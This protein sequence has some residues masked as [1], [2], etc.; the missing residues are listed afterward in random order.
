MTQYPLLSNIIVIIFSFAIIVKASDLLVFGIS[1]YARKFGISDFLIGFLVLS[2]GAS[3]PEFVSSIM[4]GFAGDGGVVFGTIL[5]SCVTAMTLS[6]GITA[7]VG[8][9]ID[10]R[11]RLLKK[12]EHYVLLIIAL[13]FLLVI[14]GKLSRIDGIILILVFLG[15]TMFLWAREGTLGQL[16]KDV[17]IKH[18]WKDILVFLGALIALLLSARWLVFSLIKTS[19]IIGVNSY[20]I[21]IIVIGIGATLPDITVQVRALLSGHSFVGFG[22]VLGSRVVMLLV[23]GIVALISP[24]VINPRLLII[25]ALFY[26][27]ASIFLLYRIRHKEI[28]WRHGIALVCFYVLFTIIQ[29]VFGII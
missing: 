28:D 22:N 3:L 29:L 4:G 2:I 27:S 1:N 5:G 25:G 10:L 14:D 20:I 11:S 7:L 8:K 23:A 17:K 9:K 12:T 18:L 15:Y 21:A 19:T 13:P 26:F 24:V 16:K 6:L